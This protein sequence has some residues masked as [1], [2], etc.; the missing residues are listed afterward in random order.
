MDTTIAP[1]LDCSVP[2]P[3]SSHSPHLPHYHSDSVDQGNPAEPEQ[4]DLVMQAE[5]LVPELRPT[6]LQ[7][8][9]AAGSDSETV[10]KCAPSPDYLVDI[11]VGAAA[12]ET[13]L[14]GDILYTVGDTGGEGRIYYFPI[15]IASGTRISARCQNNS[16]AS[17]HVG[18]AIILTTDSGLDVTAFTAC[19]TMGEN[20]ADS[21]GT[22]VDPG[23]SANT[24]SGYV[25][26]SASTSNNYKAF[27]VIVGQVGNT[28]LADAHFLFDIATGA[29][30]SETDFLSNL[31][32]STSSASDVMSP[33]VFGPF[34]CDIPSTSRLSVRGQSSTTNATDRLFDIVAYGIY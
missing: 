12:S 17:R 30:S 32:F 8:E 27:M 3:T 16:A 19:D 6:Q 14:I 13:V 28:A 25:E 31:S 20:T 5:Q 33:K 29:A 15:S 24:K 11:G 22:Q 18:V 4:S 2:V 23:G 7:H 21:G 26:L 10:A 1:V 9:T 34:A